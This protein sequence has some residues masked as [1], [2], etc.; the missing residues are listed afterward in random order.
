MKKLIAIALL[1]ASGIA[2]AKC[3]INQPYR[4]YTGMNGKQVCGCF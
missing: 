2:A 1:L 4:C 3:P